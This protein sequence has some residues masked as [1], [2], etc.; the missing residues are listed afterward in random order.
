M[1]MDW[2]SLVGQ[3]PFVAAFIWYAREVQRNINTQNMQFLE[4]LNNQNKL[5][6]DRNRALVQAI[7]ANTQQL[8]EMTKCLTSHDA[9]VDEFIE[10]NRAPVTRGRKIQ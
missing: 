8:M 4:A 2:T 1:Q 6:E 3:I 10:A 5:Y 7:T 9:K